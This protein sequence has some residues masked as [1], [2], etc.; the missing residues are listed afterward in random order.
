MR[1]W[2]DRV[3]KARKRWSFNGLMGF[4]REKVDCKAEK[5]EEG[6]LLGDFDGVTGEF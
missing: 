5:Q 6:I 1:F 2:E 3:E 4:E